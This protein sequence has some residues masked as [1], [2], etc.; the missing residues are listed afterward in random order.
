M[1]ALTIAV[2]VVDGAKMF[3]LSVP[4]EVFGRDRSFVEPWYD[5]AFCAPQDRPISTDAGF[6][7]HTDRDYEA[8]AEAHTVIVTACQSPGEVDPDLVAAV[9]AAYDAGARVVSLCT[10]AFVLA[11]AGILD[12]R[13]ATT[14]WL[15]ADQLAAQ[16]PRVRVD[17]AVLYIDD[18]DVLTSAGTTAGLDLCLHLVRRDYGVAVANALAKRLVLPMHR[19]GGQAQYIDAPVV[20][21]SD[22]LSP[23]LEWARE[24]LREPL[25]VADLARRAR[26]TE[27]TLIRRFHA[28]TG[29][30]PM[31]WLLTQ[32]IARARELL[33]STGAPVDRVAADAG[34]GSA[35]NLRHHFSRQVGV[36][37]TAYRRSFQDAF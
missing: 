21:E 37:P 34:M 16:F 10:G 12:D 7:P 20:D 31:K 9:R 24:R 32:R 25:T 23:L 5:F 3:G 15:Y 28:V 18:G 26:L 27:R 19:P 17:P 33:E 30:T 6:A 11:A 2:P 1:A 36:S 13:P 22:D 8:L 14:H 29:T 4:W 35:A